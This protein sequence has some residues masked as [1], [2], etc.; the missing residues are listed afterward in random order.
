MCNILKTGVLV[1]LA[2]LSVL[3][4]APRIKITP[5]DNAYVSRGQSIPLNCHVLANP[6]AM[7]KWLDPLGNELA[8]PLRPNPDVAKA[9]VATVTVSRPGMYICTAAN[10]L[11]Q[12]RASVLVEVQGKYGTYTM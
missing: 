5:S 3:S 4:V 6:A 1:C 2:P 9:V 10:Y 7:V 12:V 8:F 11:A